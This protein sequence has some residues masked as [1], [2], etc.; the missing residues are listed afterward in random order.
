MKNGYNDRD[1]PAHLFGAFD[2]QLHRLRLAMH[3]YLVRGPTHEKHGLKA[4]IRQTTDDLLREYIRYSKSK[5]RSRLYE[6]DTL[7]ETL[8]HLWFEYKTLGYL[9]YKNSRGYENDRSREEQRY[10]FIS[11]RIDQLGCLIGAQIKQEKERKS[12]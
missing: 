7:V 1:K 6:L 4:S 5:T 3:I 10:R 12:A 8:R 9:R 11:S 2:I